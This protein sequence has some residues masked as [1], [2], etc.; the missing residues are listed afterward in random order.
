MVRMVL[1]CVLAITTLPA[2][3]GKSL[4]YA[5]R[6]FLGNGMQ[7][8][9]VAR[10]LSSV[11]DEW[12]VEATHFMRCELSENKANAIKDCDSVPE[13]FSK[14]CATVVN[15]IV[16]GSGGDPQVTKEYMVDVCSQNNMEAW[17]RDT[18]VALA[19]DLTR[20]MGTST[21]ENRNSFQSKAA[22]DD[23][24]GHFLQVQKAVHSKDYKEIEERQRKA[25][26]AAAKLARKEKEEAEK[27]QK[28]KAEAEQRRKEDAAK[29]KE[30]DKKAQKEAELEAA[31]QKIKLDEQ[32]RH[33]K[34]PAIVRMQAVEEA[35]EQSV[36]E[37][38]QVEEG[39]EDKAAKSTETSKAHDVLAAADAAIMPDPKMYVPP[40]A[41][42]E[43]NSTKVGVVSA[44]PRNV[45]AANASIA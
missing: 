28:E 25:A 36:K 38:T 8:E 34:D 24:W 30:A 40:T 19:R 42:I 44:A 7:P 31:R 21:Y 10:T 16:Q 3:A 20:K 18:C 4:L 27:R 15:A 14:S 23:F 41:P 43:S 45:T 5:G 37:A 22:C 39:T 33:S 2:V 35:A 29:K 12:Q 13:K 9:V 1:C 17:R 26:E 11:E 32:R 6:S